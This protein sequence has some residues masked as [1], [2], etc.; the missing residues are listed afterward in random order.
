MKRITCPAAILVLF[1]L[2]GCISLKPVTALST[3]ALKTLSVFEEIPT[4]YSVFCNER[5]E[6][7]L[8]RKNEIVRDTGINC[9]CKLF[10][11]ADKATMKVYNALSAYFKSLGELSDGKLTEFQTKAFSEALVEGQFASLTIDKNTVN[12]YSSLGKLVLQ[13]F[14]DGYRKK[15]LKAVI[16]S[17]NPSI[18]VLI[19]VFEKSV[20]NLV[21]ELNFQKERTFALYRELIM[22][23]QTGYDKI[24][25]GNDYYNTINSLIR[26]QQQLETFSRT[27]AVLAKGHQALYDNRNKIT[28]KEIR[29]MLGDYSAT[30]Q[31]LITDFKKL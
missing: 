16:E 12:A 8:I 31:D 5:C 4:T 19:P 3:K 26:K 20:A 22:E 21:M 2:A 30:L 1:L 24:N 27:L 10:T 23:P 9:E 17:A 6:F 18:Q 14:T 15:K 28:S 13:A 11:A 7:A 29:E 25:L